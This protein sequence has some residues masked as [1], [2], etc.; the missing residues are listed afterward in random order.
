MILATGPKPYAIF[1]LPYFGPLRV[2]LWAMLGSRGFCCH[3]APASTDT[4]KI[5]ENCIASYKCPRDPR[6]PAQT[7]RRSKLESTICY[8]CNMVGSAVLPVPSRP[9]YLVSRTELTTLRTFTQVLGIS[10]RAFLAGRP[11][12]K[13][14][15]GTAENSSPTWFGKS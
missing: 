10:R 5:E 6:G 7:A 13:T 9:P 12:L 14:Q 15:K 11:R 4:S 1:A 2:R 3:L 8:H